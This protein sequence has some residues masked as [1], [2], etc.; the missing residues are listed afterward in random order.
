MEKK[1][2]LSSARNIMYQ[3]GENI[4]DG[5]SEKYFKDVLVKKEYGGRYE[6]I[7]DIYVRK[8]LDD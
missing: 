3:Q 6:I 8:Y 1:E 7:D 5:T 2:L 4:S